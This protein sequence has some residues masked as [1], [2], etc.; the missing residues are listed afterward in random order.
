MQD[1]QFKVNTTKPFLVMSEVRPNDRGYYHC[2]ATN[3]VGSSNKSSAGL[4]TIN[5]KC[6][7]SVLHS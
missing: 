3:D 6:N 1:D 5:G 2:I 7:E 4:L